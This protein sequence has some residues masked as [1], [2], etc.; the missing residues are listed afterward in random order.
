[1]GAGNGYTITSL[2][3]GD[4]LWA[5][6]MS[7]TNKRREQ[8]CQTQE[9]FPSGEISKGNSNG[10]RVTSLVFAAG[11]WVLVMTRFDE[12]TTTVKPLTA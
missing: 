11:I 10:H 9:Q 8:Y 5:V 7:L 2:A 3:Y 6:V 1:M 4:A 12:K